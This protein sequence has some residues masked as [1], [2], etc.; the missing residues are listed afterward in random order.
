MQ[1]QDLVT[2]GDSLYICFNPPMNG[3]ILS[4]I[5]IF[6]MLLLVAGSARA[7]NGKLISAA[8]ENPNPFY[9]KAG[10]KPPLI[11]DK[12]MLNEQR[13]EEGFVYD[14]ETEKGMVY[15]LKRP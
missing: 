4:V 5:I 13:P 10:V 6:S 11:K 3:R 8:G 15:Q 2:A 14:L 7:G 1:K 12:S 9:A